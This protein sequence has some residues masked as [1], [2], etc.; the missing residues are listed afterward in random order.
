MAK[1]FKEL[2]SKMPLRAQKEIDKKVRCLLKK[3]ASSQPT[4]RRECVRSRNH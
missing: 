4:K 1:N 2:V 3:T